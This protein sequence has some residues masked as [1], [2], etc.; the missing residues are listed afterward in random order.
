MSSRG[1]ILV[2]FVVVLALAGVETY[3][4]SAAREIVPF[5]HDLQSAADEAAR[6]HKPIF[7]DFTASWC[8][9][10]QT[11][12]GTTWAS[13]AVRDALAGYVPV[14]IDIDAYPDVARSYQVD[15]IPH[16]ALCDADG[17]PQR[18]SEGLMSP[19]AFIAWLGHR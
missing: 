5:R 7:I 9:P 1:P 17:K 11:M 8:E 12:R 6:T 19:D 2:L 15:G 4:H 14:Q 16:L 3:W 18:M 10:C 13:P